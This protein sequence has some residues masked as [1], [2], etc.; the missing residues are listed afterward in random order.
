MASSLDH[1]VEQE[2]HGL[3]TEMPGFLSEDIMTGNITHVTWATIKARVPSEGD[4]GG[5][6]ARM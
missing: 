3:G 4:L 5:L 2:E 1:R 6:R